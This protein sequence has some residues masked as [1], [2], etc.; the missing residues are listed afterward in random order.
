MQPQ[1]SFICLPHFSLCAAR[2]FSSSTART[3]LTI[4]M[5]PI[6][7]VPWQIPTSALR[8]AF[9]LSKC[10]HKSK[11]A[12]AQSV[13]F[14]V[15]LLKGEAEGL[16]VGQGSRKNK[17]AIGNDISRSP[18]TNQC[19]KQGHDIHFQ[20]PICINENFKGIHPFYSSKLEH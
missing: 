17:S 5:I 14:I 20:K 19:P 1:C 12:R 16:L 18:P 15:S 4:Q 7:S 10:A 2:N 3:D 9:D 13:I 6:V 8:M 11:Q